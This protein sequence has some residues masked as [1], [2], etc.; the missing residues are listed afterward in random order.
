[1]G[2]G[3]CRGA[4]EEEGMKR[5]D[6][7][8]MNLQMFADGGAPGSAG[9]DPASDP[10]ND[11]GE[12]EGGAE[13]EP[14][15]YSQEE[16]D[17]QLQA[18]TDKRVTQ[19]LKTAEEKWSSMLEAKLAEERTKA[20]RINLK[21]LP[22]ISIKVIALSPIVRDAHRARKSLYLDFIFCRVAIRLR[23]CSSSIST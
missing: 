15:S 2:E 14:K 11:S 16:F 8:R 22:V 9:G 18:E 4:N 3:T 1:M 6:V 20:E 19:A 17:K 12:G 23:R 5:N 21:E 7:L 10:S 13:G